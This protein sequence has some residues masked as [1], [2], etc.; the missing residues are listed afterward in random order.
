MPA[1]A[2]GSQLGWGQDACGAGVGTVPCTPVPSCPPPRQH[3][4]TAVTSFR[5]SQPRG[6]GGPHALG[7]G[8]SQPSSPS[9]SGWGGG[10]DPDTQ[11]QE[12]FGA[13]GQMEAKG[14]KEG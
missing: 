12:G 4:H 11:L 7:N 8:G 5:R 3:T 1:P 13:T 10:R 6:A 2:G 14:P 9:G